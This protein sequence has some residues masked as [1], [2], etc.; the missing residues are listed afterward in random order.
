MP[1]RPP[2]QLW[3]LLGTA[4][5][6]GLAVVISVAM[7]GTMGTFLTAGCWLTGHLL[8]SVGSISLS[9]SPRLSP[10]VAASSIQL[11]FCFLTI[12]LL[13]SFI[14]LPAVLLAAVQMFVHFGNTVRVQRL[15]PHDTNPTHVSI[16]VTAEAPVAKSGTDKTSPSENDNSQ[17]SSEIDAGREQALLSQLSASTFDDQENEIADDHQE[18]PQ[19]IQFQS[20]ERDIV[21]RYERGSDPDG[22]E[23]LEGTIRVD[24][25]RHQKTAVVH[26]PF[27]PAFQSRPDV[28]S[29]LLDGPHLKIEVK[30]VERWGI[31]LELT[32]RAAGLDPDS[33]ELAF[34]VTSQSA[35]RG[36]A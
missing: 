10:S 33:A 4:L 32:R 16:Q 24:F 22:R 13:P 20:A 27:W 35:A 31:R 6:C 15:Q 25:L 5:L 34:F 28:N 7:S 14:A 21:Q 19:A 11:L 12:P 2:V 29:E 1:Y 17:E 23:W 26:I 9:N 3:Q 8:I 36:A 30:T 18:S